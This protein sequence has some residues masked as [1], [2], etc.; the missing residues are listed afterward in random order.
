MGTFIFWLVIVYCL[1]FIGYIGYSAYMLRK[2]YLDM[3]AK[4]AKVKFLPKVAFTRLMEN[5]GII[6]VM[7]MVILGLITLVVNLIS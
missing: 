5:I 4:K 7:Y 6:T 2:H 3:K 1:L